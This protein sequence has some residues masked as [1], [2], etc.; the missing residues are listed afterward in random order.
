MRLKEED[1]T[2]LMCPYYFLDV[3]IKTRLYDSLSSIIIFK[4]LHEASTTDNVFS[5]NFTYSDIKNSSFIQKIENF[6]IEH[7]KVGKQLVFEITENES[8]ESYEEVKSFI[9]RFRKYG[10][11]IAI[12]DFGTGF[13]NFEY[14]LEVEPD[15]LKIDGSLVKDIDTNTRSFTL[16]EAIVQFSHK[17]GI[18][19][20]AEFVHSKVIFDMLNELHVDEYQGYYFSEPKIEI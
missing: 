10:V 1:N 11:K 20:I 2:I 7:N 19:V 13:S 15:Y 14:I 18:K 8:I 16:V 4:A 12:D 5:I 3:A 6:L 17:L 9:L